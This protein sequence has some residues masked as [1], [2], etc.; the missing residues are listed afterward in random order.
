MKIFLGL[1]LF[2]LVSCL[3]DESGPQ[4]PGGSTPGS[5]SSGDDEMDS[6]AWSSDGDPDPCGGSTFEVIT[7]T[8]LEIPIACDPNYF[9]KG[10]PPPDSEHSYYENP[11]DSVEL[12]PEA[13]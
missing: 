13:M 10:D 7:G 8:V 1:A 4:N 11:S 6:F 2:C 9:D 12:L 3:S 5:S